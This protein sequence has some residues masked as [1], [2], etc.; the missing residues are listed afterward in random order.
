[1]RAMLIA[2]VAAL[3]SLTGVGVA[4][5]TG[6]TAPKTIVEVQGDAGNGFGIHYYDGTAVYPPTDSEAKAECGEYDT[7]RARVRCRSEV[8]TWYDDLAELQRS[9]EWALS[10]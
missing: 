10:Q 4:V 8:R 5:A 1:M 3:A 6:A 2:V 7:L 9:L